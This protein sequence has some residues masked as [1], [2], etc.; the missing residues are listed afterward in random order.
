MRLLPGWQIAHGHAL[1][2]PGVPAYA[3]QAGPV[4]LDDGV[5]VVE[6]LHNI[7]A[8]LAALD[9]RQRPVERLRRLSHATGRVRSRCIRQRGIRPRLSR[10]RNAEP[11]PAGRLSLPF[12]EH[13][14]EIT[15]GAGALLRRPGML[16]QAGGKLA[17]TTL[18]RGHSPDDDGIQGS[19]TRLLGSA[20][21]PLAIHQHENIIVAEVLQDNRRDLPVGKQGCTQCIQ[22]L[23]GSASARATGVGNDAVQAHGLNDQR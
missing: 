23:V 16:V 22:R 8:T 12:A 21:A 20:P 18:E 5:Q 11:Q 3:G 2:C 13:H 19:Q 7:R 10:N 6:R 17:L 4:L 9:A 14:T 1:C 15:E